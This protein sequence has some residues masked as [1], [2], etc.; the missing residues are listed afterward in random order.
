MNSVMSLAYRGLGKSAESEGLKFDSSWGL[1][2]LF[3]SHAR[4]KTKNIFLKIY[5]VRQLVSQSNLCEGRQLYPFFEFFSFTRH[6][7]KLSFIYPLEAQPAGSD[8]LISLA[9]RAA[10]HAT[11]Q[12]AK[13]RSAMALLSQSHLTSF[14]GE[15]YLTNGK[16]HSVHY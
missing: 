9:T 11:F 6:S 15:L 14:T 4:D 5:S 13:G 12:P 2:I 1:R 7:R 8:F 10:K 16:H 3:L